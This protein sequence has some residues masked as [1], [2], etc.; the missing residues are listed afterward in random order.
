[1]TNVTDPLA[2]DLLMKM[3]SKNPADRFLHMEAVLS[4]PYFGDVGAKEEVRN[5]DERSDELSDELA[6]H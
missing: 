4:H 6:T 3:L 5:C 1:M 2:Q